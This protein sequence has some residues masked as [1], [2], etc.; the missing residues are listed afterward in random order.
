MLQPKILFVAPMESMKL[1]LEYE[2]GEK[3]LFDVEPYANGP[4]YGMLRDPA[5]FRTVHVVSGGTGIEWEEG[6]DIAP[7]ELYDLG[8][9]I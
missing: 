6:Q 4:W 3:K 1:K 2:T 8:K 7:H 9:P 5:Y